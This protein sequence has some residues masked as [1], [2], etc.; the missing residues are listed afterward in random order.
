MVKVFARQAYIL[1]RLSPWVNLCLASDVIVK[2]AIYSYI[3]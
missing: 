1:G 2:L 3:I